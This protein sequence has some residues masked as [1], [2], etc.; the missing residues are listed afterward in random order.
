M[1]QGS[2]KKLSRS[3]QYLFQQSFLSNPSTGFLPE[4]P[5]YNQRNQIPD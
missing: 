3:K 1:E 2:E 4:I 5:Q